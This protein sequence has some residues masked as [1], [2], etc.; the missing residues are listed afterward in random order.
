MTD[1]NG[2]SSLLNI[3]ISES[4]KQTWKE[5][6]AEE[7]YGT[8]TNLIKHSVESTLSDEWVLKSN[9]EIDIDI[10]EIDIGMENIGPVTNS[11]RV[12]LW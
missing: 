1:E 6:A 11:S 5:Y 8:L 2:S 12:R 3:R 4:Q 10:D 7:G 9:T